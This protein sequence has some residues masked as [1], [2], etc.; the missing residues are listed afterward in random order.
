M[1]I[2]R[3]FHTGRTIGSVGDQSFLA[4]AAEQAPT[5]PGATSGCSPRSLLLETKTTTSQ[6]SNAHNV[7]LPRKSPPILARGLQPLSAP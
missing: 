7:S 2:C 4:A 3:D 1:V 5:L 6:L